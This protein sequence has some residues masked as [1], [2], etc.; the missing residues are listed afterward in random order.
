M[1]V[2]SFVDTALPLLTSVY[3]R[4]AWRDATVLELFAGGPA[5]S[6][7]VI[8]EGARRVLS[9]GG[10]LPSGKNDR[11]ERWNADP[12]TVLE[13]I[14]PERFSVVLALGV[15]P[16]QLGRTVAM[17]KRVVQPDGIFVVAV[18][19]SDRA[20][21]KSDAAI[22]Y[23]KLVDELEP[24]FGSVQMVGLAPFV[25]A[26]L[27][28]YGNTEAT[29][30][31][32]GSLVPK[33]E[34]VEWYVA[35]AGGD[36]QPR[37]FALVQSKAPAVE[38]AKAES[39]SAP[40]P[41]A[42]EVKKVDD[43]ETR[44]KLTE[45]EQKNAELKRRVDDL[46]QKE[47]AAT[48]NVA[49][50]VAELEKTRTAARHGASSDEVRLKERIAEL[51]KL[52]EA[53]AK[54]EESGELAA[55]RRELEE[56]RGQRKTMEVDRDEKADEARRM[57]EKVERLEA[58]L[59]QAQRGGMGQGGDERVQALEIENQK[60]RE[61]EEQARSEAWKHLK[62]RSEAE[63]Q[64]AEVR[65]DTVRKLKDARKLASVELMRAMEEATKK[66]VALKED[67]ERTLAENKELKK[68]LAAATAQAQAAEASSEQERRNPAMDVALAAAERRIETLLGTVRDLERD[69]DAAEQRLAEE[70]QRGPVQPENSE[71]LIDALRRAADLQAELARKDLQL[72]RAA[73]AAA[74]ERARAERMIADERRALSLRNE[75]KARA[76]D[77]EARAQQLA[78]Q[79]SALEGALA[80]E[81]ERNGSSDHDDHGNE[82]GESL[83][84]A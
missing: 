82:N 37:G 23:Y 73:Q 7:R 29:P 25:G 13:R 20:P 22:S 77:A 28:E 18:R 21:Q 79:V 74:H 80:E 17:A 54:P 40:K 72:E 34:R 31:L 64:A 49:Q 46:I 5:L 61:R 16:Q 65:E 35:I 24:H 14:G 57:R 55:V 43:T 27:A 2:P 12:L 50:L 62:A 71:S 78:A 39:A 6:D 36:K 1:S 33:G 9:V 63:A 47:K 83:A 69:V 42:K 75:A 15:L 45:L 56:M 51:E 32:D 4:D 19:S 66:S 67:L 8:E 26:T 58:A 3:L 10:K 60:L 41:E 48:G 81:R 53:P 52:V 44:K 38:V 68:Q 59:E 30:I 70:R 11:A 76:A 84:G